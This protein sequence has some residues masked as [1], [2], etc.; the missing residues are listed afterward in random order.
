MRPGYGG[1]VGDGA[2]V[3]VQDMCGALVVAD[4]GERLDP[5]QCVERVAAQEADRR[6]DGT[7]EAAMLMAPVLAGLRLTRRLEVEMRSAARGASGTRQDDPQNV[8][9][10]VLADHVAEGE[11][12]GGR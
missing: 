5:R 4:L 10:L 3:V 6:F 11:Q 8:P 9:M 7:A 12:L 1:A 2:R